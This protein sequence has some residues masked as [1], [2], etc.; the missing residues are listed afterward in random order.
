[1]PDSDSAVTN[2]AELAR[3]QNRESPK[4]VKKSSLVE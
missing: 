1:M 2:R 3:K 4:N